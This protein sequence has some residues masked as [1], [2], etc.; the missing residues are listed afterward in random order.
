VVIESVAKNSEGEKAGFAEGDILLSWSRGD[1]K[2]QI[3]SPFDLS[4]V[5]MEQEPRGAVTL[6]GTR[7]ARKQTWMIGPDKWGIQTR[8]ILP[9]AL[10]T[11]YSELQN[12]VK[13]GK[14]EGAVPGWQSIAVEARKRPCDWLSTWLLFHAAGKLAEER[15]WK[16]SDVLYQVA[17]DSAQS[18]RR[19][20]RIQLLRAWARTFYQRSDYANAERLYQ[21][22]AEENQK[23]GSESLS[24]AAN[25]NDLGAM[26]SEHGDPTKAKEYLQESLKITKK[27]APGSLPE[28]RSLS[29]FGLVLLNTGDLTNAEEAYQQSRAIWNKL[30][31][32]SLGLADCF[33]SLGKLSR[34]RGELAKAEDFLRKSLEIQ[35]KLLPAS[36]DVG[37]TLILLASIVYQQ[38]KS[39]DAEEYC[40]RSLA[41]EEKL[42]PESL[43]FASILGT[44]GNIVAAR[45]DLAKSEEYF[46]R[47]L[48]IYEQLV[49]G[50]AYVATVLNNLGS[51]SNLR[52]DLTKAEEYFRK[53]LEIE[54]KVAAGSVNVAET[55]L[56]LGIIAERRGD[57]AQAEEFDQQA[58][59]I[60][61][62]DSPDSLDLAMN[63]ITIGDLEV[64]RGN[65]TRA[66]EYY[67]R[68][69]AIY[70]KQAPDGIDVA[71]AYTGLGNLAQ[72]RRDFVQAEEY[73]RRALA[74]REKQ[75]PDSLEVAASLNNLGRIE[76]NRD[77]LPVA[78]THLQRALGIYKKLAP[79]SLDLAE[80]LG[81]LGDLAL[82]ERDLPHAE[83]DY[84]QARAI[85]EK[86]APGNRAM[87]STLENLG[88]LAFGRGD[89]AK[90][91]E[92][93]RQSLAIVE[94]LSSDSQQYGELLAS[95]AEVMRE[96][97]QPDDA[98]VLYGNALDALDGQLARLGGSNDVR[99]SFRAKHADYYIDY[100]GLLLEQGKRDVAFQVL[101]RS[102]ART[103]LESLAEAR[104]DIHEGAPPAL[105][106]Q[107]HLLQA[108]LKAKSN[109][110]ISLLEGTHNDKQLAEVNQ[111]INAVLKQY[112]D[113]E[114]QIRSRSPNYA[115]LTQPQPL[116]AKQV[117][118]DLLDPETAL[119][120]YALGEK[121]SHVFLVTRTSLETFELPK[122]SEIEGSA[123]RVYG[124]LTSRDLFIKGETTAQR[125]ARIAKD[126][127]EY[128]TAVAALSQMILGPVATRLKGSR[129]LIVADGA[130]QYIPFAAL[131]V[132]RDEP[133][134]PPVP[135][136]AEHEIINLPSASVLALLRQQT[137][138]RAARP[139]EVV[140]FADPVFDKDD[141]RVN[142][143]K[144]IAKSEL[145]PEKVP[146]AP[147]PDRLTRSL[148]DVIGGT[149]AVGSGLPR[150]FFSRQEAK[151][152]MALTSHD[153]SLEALDFQASRQLALS[154]ELGQYRIVHFATHGL[155]D[156]E[157]PELSGLV[158]SLV[159]T[160]GK[161]QNGFLELQDV[162]N[163][164]LPVDLVV[165]SAC[166]T[167]LGKE[168]NGEGLIGLTRGFMYAGAPRVVASLWKVDDLATAN[169]MGRFYKAMLK[170]GMRPAAALRQAQLEMWKD[171]R[172][173]EPYNWAAFTIQ[174]EWK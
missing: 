102:R 2:G 19:E 140:V 114:G 3:E 8:P 23:A 96:K 86:L 155:L 67:Q 41:I 4:G 92:N 32:G 55:S 49:P 103:L 91:E 21:Q 35:E 42:N 164:D 173:N 72:E 157:H 144:V 143:S 118:E 80:I 115:A 81:T 18:V 44:L 68:S 124:L 162:Y 34:A 165:L 57:L 111:E 24:A 16:H 98:Q 125:D 17:K 166:E 99:T 95:L 76:G 121:R 25:L 151:S 61:E 47:V 131:P 63:L 6:E 64:D 89:L 132:P 66:E 94:K 12:L 29:N 39:A 30:A 160:H 27:L 93:F 37:R 73:A 10:L 148:G 110:R 129:L 84:R 45:G 135:L 101:E 79:S 150:L 50:T 106:E 62:K 97:G 128:Q 152:I 146:S 60:L 130:L 90:A 138:G 156:N 141:P 158:L 133:S 105:L 11:K 107:E 169:L 52:G 122:R 13:A 7:G 31:P 154:K 87:A 172:W 48:T 134:K 136:I 77:N 161:P 69:L 38:G 127:G 100:A 88:S 119:L 147:L 20:A 167:G 1:A 58:L 15:S 53:S 109:R 28:A 56:N 74:I 36:D 22:A 85:L 70:Q 5:E 104:I 117:Q 116:T 137:N 82:A 54:M 83:E 43:V 40:M 9:D 174:G 59:T 65:L 26:F 51:I 71:R 145:P 139:K 171:K 46:E 123:R 75:A 168:I 14:F 170:D 108:T 112:Q 159:D 120:E 153:E 163:L 78:E 113:V 149:R 126:K 33:R 142:R